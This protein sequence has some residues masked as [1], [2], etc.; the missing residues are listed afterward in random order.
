MTRYDYETFYIGGR[1]Q[2]A[3]SSDRVAITSSVDGR[4]LGV[5]P[6]ATPADVDAAVAA[7]RRAIAPGAPWPSLDREG[8]AVAIESFATAMKAQ[9]ASLG[10]L[11]AEEV[12]SP[13]TLATN[14]NAVSAISQLRFYA[15]TARELEFE[16]RRPAR[17]GESIVRRLPVGVVAAIIP[18][19]FPISLAIYKLGPALAAGCTVVL[20]PSPETGLSSYV[21]ADAIAASELPPGVI[22]IVPADREVGEYL[23]SHPG[24]DK[25]SF[26]GSTDA[27][28]R[29]AAVAGQN[30][31]PVTLELGGKSAAIVLPDA[32]L[33]AF[34]A[35]LPALSFMN[36]GQT[37]TLDS[38][39]LVPR[40]RA[41]EFTEA[42][43]DRAGR[44]VIGSPL[45]SNVE[46]GP[47]VSASQR[48]RVERY[49]DIGRD[50]GAK[51]L[52]GAGRP[53]GF[54]E[55]LFVRPTVFGG[56]EPSMRVAR[57]EIFGPVVTIQE[58]AD[59]DDAA[60]ELANDSDFGLA[61]TVWS[62]DQ[63][64]AEAVARQVEAGVVGAN[65]WNL[66]LGA[67]FGGRKDSGIG[68][69]LG[70]EAVDPY[71]VY[72]SVYVPLAPQERQR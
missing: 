33:E 13:L 44:L 63:E 47:L 7:A 72:Q 24:I 30:L 62:S 15:Q 58:Y 29:V 52:T 64:H 38:R 19:N 56:V 10:T 8:R 40:S 70:P 34:L 35:Q 14:A 21:L 71:L 61:G 42:I 36:N 26:T 55:G 31:K 51:V 25:I 1:H 18:W 59:T 12:G 54:D 66:D 60:I 5:Y 2:A 20:K 16:T 9:V 65:V 17:L 49:I 67:P 46:I 69:E 39:I 43:V 6:V 3:T 23:V 28:R 68:H 11:I 37:C 57:E 50:E 48:E 4:T 27:G 45:D 53:I 41:D 32:D 22:N